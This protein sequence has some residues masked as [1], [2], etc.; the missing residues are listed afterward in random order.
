FAVLLGERLLAAAPVDQ[1]PE[2][3]GQVGAGG[4]EGDVL[5]NAV[6]PDLEVVLVEPGHQAPGG[7][8][9]AGGHADALDLRA[10]G[11]LLSEGAGARQHSVLNPLAARHTA[12]Y[13]PSRWRVSKT[14]KVSNCVELPIQVSKT[15]V[16]AVSRGHSFSL[17]DAPSWTTR[18]FGG[19][20]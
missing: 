16:A 2:G 20:S 9:D 6:F 17:P 10:K 15:E 8:A 19:S 1:Q 11:R 3:E 5:A 4:E 18:C 13:A 14:R 12:Q 7:I